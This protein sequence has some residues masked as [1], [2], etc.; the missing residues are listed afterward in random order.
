MIERE[1]HMAELRAA[2]ERL[3][4]IAR[5]P[6]EQRYGIAGPEHASNVS[7]RTCRTSFFQRFLSKRVLSSAFFPA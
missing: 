3:V 4:P 2:A 7:T 6:I 5:V 1:K